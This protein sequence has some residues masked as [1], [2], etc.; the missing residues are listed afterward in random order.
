METLLLNITHL[1]RQNVNAENRKTAYGYRWKLR[2]EKDRGMQCE[3]K[4]ILSLLD[5][6]YALEPD[7]TKRQLL[8]IIQ[9]YH[10]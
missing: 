1:K 4:S 3:D 10:T 2:Q 7:E 6:A 9:K 5:T 8:K